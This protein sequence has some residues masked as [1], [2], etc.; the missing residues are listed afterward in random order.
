MPRLKNQ[1][2]TVVE[3]VF[4]LA[5]GLIVLTGALSVLVTTYKSSGGGEVRE[6]VYRNARFVGMSLERDLQTTGVGINTTSSFGT[7]AVWN[8]TI[9]TLRIP[10]SPN[11]A[12]VHN[13]VPPAGTNN[14]LAAGGTCGTYCVD[15]QKGPGAFDLK[16]G[17]LARLQVAST[18]RLILVSGVVVKDTGTMSVTFT[19]DTFL[20]HNWAGLAQGLKLDRY[21]TFVQKLSP[22]VFWDQSNQVWRAE[23]VNVGGSLKGA[24]IAYNVP[25]LK[26]SLIFA[27]SLVAASADPTGVD[28]TRT[29]DKVTGVVIHATATASRPDPRINSGQLFK[30][31]YAWR[32]SPRN[33]M[34]RY[35]ALH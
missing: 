7:L 30:H 10:Y 32:F 27:N 16:A 20:L 18:L 24:V 6:E 8:D 25:T 15:V 3:L 1:G 17:D 2:F 4:A 28:T 26:D 22:V 11:Q 13:L 14:P 12:P 19:S 21:A 34:W 35:E 9:V 29:F 5:V 23:Q 31:S 33:L